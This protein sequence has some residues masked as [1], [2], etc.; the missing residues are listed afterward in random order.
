LQL[1]AAVQFLQTI[2]GII[3]RDIK[4]ENILI[5]TETDG[6]GK[7]IPLAKLAD[8]GLSCLVEKKEAAMRTMQIGTLQY[9][10]PEMLMGEPY[11]CRIDN[12]GVGLVAYFLSSGTHPFEGLQNFKEF[13]NHVISN[14]I[15]FDPKV[16]SGR[17]M[18]K[19]AITSIIESNLTKRVMIH[20]FIRHPWFQHIV[21]NDSQSRNYF[22]Y[23]KHVCN[24]FTPPPPVLL[25]RR[26][27][28]PDPNYSQTSSLFSQPKMSQNL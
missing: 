5:K 21:E 6:S 27:I 26:S 12:Y 10:A 14:S 4:P 16:W 20:D 11:D 24:S 8:F 1:T 25:N 23:H 3:H 28:F 18:S 19:D 2:P 22:E 7:C 13:L 17:E 9:M 15:D